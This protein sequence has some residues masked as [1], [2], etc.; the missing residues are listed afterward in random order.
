MFFDGSALPAGPK[1]N[2]IN[3]RIERVKKKERRGE[4]KRREKEQNT[5]SLI[6]CLISSRSTSI[7]LCFSFLFSSI[8]LLASATSGSSPSSVAFSPPSSLSPNAPIKKKGRTFYS[9]HF[10]FWQQNKSINGLHIRLA[11]YLI[12]KNH[13]NCTPKLG[14]SNQQHFGIH[15]REGEHEVVWGRQLGHA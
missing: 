12:N 10:Y 6:C 4:G 2:V 1:G 13:P 8:S 3:Q 7:F 11:G 5:L 9:E 15:Q 14:C